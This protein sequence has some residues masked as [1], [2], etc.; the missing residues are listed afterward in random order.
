MITKDM[1]ADLIIKTDLFMSKRGR[2]IETRQNLIKSINQLTG[3]DSLDAIYTNDVSNYK[4]PDVVVLPLY[5]TDFSVYLMNP[6]NIDTCPFG[7]TIEIHS[8]C[9]DRYTPEELTAVIIHDILQN[10]QSDTAR[11]R[12]MK[13]YSDVIGDRNPEMILDAFDD[14]SLSEVTFMMFLQICCRPFRV[15]VSGPDYTGTDEF[16]K[17]YGLADAYDSYLVKALPMSIDD[18]EDRVNHEIK[19]DYRDVKTIIDSC[20][21]KDIRHYYTMIR[22]GVPL[23][24]LEHLLSKPKT[25]ASLG[26]ISRK[27]SIKKRYNPNSG[28]TVEVAPISES[29]MNPKDEIELRFQID[30][31]IS[32]M[33]YADSEAEREVMLYRI[34]TISLKLLKLMDKLNKKLKATPTDKNLQARIDIIIAYQNELEELRKKVVNMEVK[35]KVWRIFAKQDLPEG[36]DF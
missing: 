10:V 8:R 13:A 32:E 2:D 12:F 35:Q 17:A 5:H 29:F 34:K 28:T 36:Y 31:I 16:L 23:V 9:F 19:D 22:E 33:R 1:I 30:K 14:L 15:P 25:A 11:I 26:L 18:P 20:L 4:I 27:K 6:D 7:Y 21:D 24:S 3:E